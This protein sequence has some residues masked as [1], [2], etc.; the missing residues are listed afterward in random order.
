MQLR[1]TKDND[2]A[3]EVIDQL[4]ELVGGIRRPDI[5]RQMIIAALKAGQEDDGRVDLKMINSTLKEMRFTAKAFA[6]YRE[7]RKVTVF[8]SA[9]TREDEGAYQLAREFGEK[10]ARAGYMVITGAGPGIMQAVNEGAGPE[11]SFGVNIRLPFE[12]KSNAVFEGNPRLITYKYFFNRKVAFIKEA[13]A[14]VLFPGGFGTLDEAMETLTLLQTGKRYSLPLVLV[15]EPGSTYWAHVIRFFKEE[16]LERG[17]IGRSDLDL[18][19]HVQ[20]VDEAMQCIDRFYRRYHSLRYVDQRLVIRMKSD[21]DSHGVDKLKED[22]ADI[23]APGGEMFLS[24]AFEEELD[25]PEIAHLPRLV[26]DFN[27]LD[28][29]RL[30]HLIDTLNEA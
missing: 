24:G 29:G 9:R 25:E 27:R 30:R 16:L 19:E 17:Y 23:L 10:L 15:D 8:G 13:D 3:D 1:F 12:Q 22:F 14:V 28:F 20:S 26:L 11:R 21:I 18:F 4:I 5:V 2:K 7:I 6:P